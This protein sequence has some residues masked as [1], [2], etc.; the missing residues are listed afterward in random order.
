MQVRESSRW[1]GGCS[2][3]DTLSV[4]QPHFPGCVIRP[5]LISTGRQS[6]GALFGRKARWA[7]VL[8]SAAAWQSHCSAAGMLGHDQMLLAK[9]NNV[10]NKAARN[11]ANKLVATAICISQGW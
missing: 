1:G 11:M 2:A 4:C 10:H 3:M 6:G 9:W 8:G 7:A 5:V